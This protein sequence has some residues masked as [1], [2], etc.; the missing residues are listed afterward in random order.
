MS[1]GVDTEEFFVNMGPQHPATHGILR[2]LLK[3]DGEVLQ[4][5]IPYIGYLHR[6]FEKICENRTYTQVITYTDRLDYLGAMN[7]NFGYCM[8]VEHLMGVQVP[9]R[10]EYIRVIM[11]ELNR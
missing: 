10:A 6:N 11:A 7:N 5:I 4:D 9:D 3:L 1:V 8:A 2:L